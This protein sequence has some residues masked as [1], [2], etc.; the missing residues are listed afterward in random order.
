[1]ANLGACHDPSDGMPQKDRALQ[2]E[3]R[4]FYEDSKLKKED[5]K[6]KR[7]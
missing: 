6:E 4:L 5:R 7:Q 2:V 3:C 1:V